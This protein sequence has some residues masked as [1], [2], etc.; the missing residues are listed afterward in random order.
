MEKA[1]L[2]VIV[3]NYN[4][5]TYIR[6]C[7][8]S[9]LSQTYRDI[10]I[11]IYDD[12]STDSSPDIIDEYEKKYPGTIKSFSN[13]VNSGPAHTRHE[14]ILKANGKY[15]TTLDSDD[16]FL[17]PQKL[18]K[19]MSLISSYK[20]KYNKDI[21][22]FSNIVMVNNDKSIIDIW[23][24]RENIKEGPVFN[25]IIS[26]SCMI[27]RDFIMTKDAYLESGGYDN[28]FPIY[29]DWDL[30]IRLSAR[31]EFYYTGINGTAYRR[32]GKGLSSTPIPFHVKWLKNVLEKNTNLIP[33]SQKNEI[34][35][36]FNRYIAE[37]EK[38]KPQKNK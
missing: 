24:T 38:N 12:C 21:I 2:S 30:K 10:E 3:P 29:E 37:I 31:Y 9:I 14:A 25:Y 20:E 15:I 22:A 13:N 27:P 7:L 34:I 35:Y 11:I 19:E 33:D 36:M 16:Y 28:N 6:E 4:N 32:H 18:E 23:G 8:D 26:R 5:E 17:E 1:S